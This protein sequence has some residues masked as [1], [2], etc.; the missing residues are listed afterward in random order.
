MHKV[1]VI[2]PAYRSQGTIARTVASVLAQTHEA[3]DML[4]VSDDG[5]DYERCLADSG[6]RD[7]RLR[8]LT[9]G[10]VG[11]GPSNARNVGIEAAQGDV[12]ATLD[13]DDTFHERKLEWMVPLALEHGLASSEILFLEDPTGAL[14]PNHNRKFAGPLLSFEQALFAHVHTY[15]CLVWDRRIPARYAT[16]IQRME[17]TVFM[18][19]LFGSVEHLYHVPARLH[20]YY[21]R[22]GSLCNEADAASHF[23]RA[24]N[25]I[26]ERLRRGELDF[27]D[28]AV[29]RTLTL[30]IERQLFLEQA[31]EAGLAAA[32]YSDYQDFLAR[33]PE[34]ATDLDYAQAGFELARTAA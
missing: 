23:I 11:T 18:A 9:T 3:W 7:A 22:R 5:A 8:F 2:T 14:L 20:H 29:S 17:D 6:V 24:C 32:V 27:R 16:D 21:H 4:I 34:G 13:S 26:L 33:S 31:F 12:L 28:R 25:Q 19:S 30:F 1:S 10:G 15:S